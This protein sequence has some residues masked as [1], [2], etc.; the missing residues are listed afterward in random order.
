MNERRLLSIF[1]LLLVCAALFLF[2]QFDILNSTSTKSTEDSSNFKLDFDDDTVSDDTAKKKIQNAKET[3]SKEEALSH[4]VPVGATS[5]SAG[6]M[7]KGEGDKDAKKEADKDSAGEETKTKEKKN[8]HPCILRRRLAIRLPRLSQPHRPH[9][10]P[11]QIN[12]ARNDLHS[13]RR[14]H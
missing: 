14:H 5:T 9:T 2:V 11:G 7:E 3:K 1:P 10:Q 6:G 12:Q 4:V 8:E 13:K